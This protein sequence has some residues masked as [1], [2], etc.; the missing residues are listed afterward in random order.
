MFTKVSMPRLFPVAL[1][2]LPVCLLN[3]IDQVQVSDKGLTVTYHAAVAQEDE[4]QPKRQTRRAMAISEGV[5]KKLSE[6]SELLNPE[7]EGAKP[8][9]KGALK[10]AQEINTSRWNE[11]EQAQLYN[12]IGNIY[13]QMENYPEAIKYYQRYVDTESVPEANVLN[14]TWYLAQLYL[15]T[16]NYK[17]AIQM[18]EGYIARSEIV[19]ADH[20]YKLGQAYYL[21]ENLA[22]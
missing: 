7:E 22:K 15:A 9:L 3:P 14:V 6:V 2:A 20:Y 5:N 1:L 11:F 8:D 10:V 13:V 18:I 16:E 17:K 21:D 12:M 4:D 19:G